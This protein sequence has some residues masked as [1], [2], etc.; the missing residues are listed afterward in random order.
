MTNEKADILK[1]WETE[2]DG[3]S[4]YNEPETPFKLHQCYEEPGSV[5]QVYC[6]KCGN[7][8][9]EVGQGSYITVVRCAKCGHEAD[10]HN[11]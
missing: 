11:G 8:E 1:D 2:Y 9:L 4:F 7:K 5:K 10:I 3:F 6:A